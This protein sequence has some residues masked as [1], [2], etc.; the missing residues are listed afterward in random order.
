VQGLHKS[1]I[2]RLVKF[3]WESKTPVQV[4]GAP[5]E[6]HTGYTPGNCL[7][8]L[9]PAVN[10]MITLSPFLTSLP[11]V[12]PMSIVVSAPTFFSPRATV[13]PVTADWVS[14]FGNFTSPLDTS[15]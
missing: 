8:I 15:I 4:N 6:V 7:I 2:V 10:A 1:V 13:N 12:K 14:R 3:P 5:P 9:D 11:R